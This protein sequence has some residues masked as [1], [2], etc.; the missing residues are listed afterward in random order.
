[1]E[2]IND[3]LKTHTLDINRQPVNLFNF[4]KN[5]KLIPIPQLLYSREIVATK[6]IRQL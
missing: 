5:G 4:D 3:Q 6:I 2:F 1:F